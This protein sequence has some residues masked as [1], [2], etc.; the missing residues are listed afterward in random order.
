ME[1]TDRNHGTN[2]HGEPLYMPKNGEYSLVV[3]MPVIESD[4]ILPEC[5]PSPHTLLNFLGCSG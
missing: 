2:T 3:C 4:N 5:F 1:G